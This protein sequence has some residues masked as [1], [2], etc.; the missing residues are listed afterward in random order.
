MITGIHP[1]AIGDNNS[2]LLMSSVIL[3]RTNRR[4]P[5]VIPLKIH[6]LHAAETEEA[7]AHRRS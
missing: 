2:D 3:E 5:A 4:N 6:L 7:Q 1:A